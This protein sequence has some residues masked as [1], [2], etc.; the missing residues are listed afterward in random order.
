[1]NQFP[2]FGHTRS[3]DSLTYALRFDGLC[4][5]NTIALQRLHM[6]RSC[7]ARS[8]IRS[9]EYNFRIRNRTCLMIPRT[10]CDSICCI[11]QILV[12]DLVPLSVVIA[13]R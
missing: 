12:N 2:K 6:K 5:N 9:V 11:Y 7:K 1:M 10:L 4:A 8:G 13:M 3:C